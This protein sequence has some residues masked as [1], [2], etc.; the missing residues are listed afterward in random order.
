MK[1]LLLAALLA[2]T[3]TAMVPGMDEPSPMFAT[4]GGSLPIVQ[5]QTQAPA[6]QATPSPGADGPIV[7]EET[8]ID[9]QVM[10]LSAELRCPVC[11]G[12]SLADSPSELSLEMREVVRSLLEEGKSPAEVRAY[13]VSKYGEWILLEPD[14]KGFNMAVYILPI[15]ALLG[16]VA[17]VVMLVKRW[18]NGP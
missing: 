14:P 13:F 4:S 12:L 8:A 5:A 11:Q 3:P 16:G 1:T 9:R 2:H 7:V 18:S 17:F 15:V 6:A 10:A